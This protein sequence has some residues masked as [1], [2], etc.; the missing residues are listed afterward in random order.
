GGYRHPGLSRSWC[1]VAADG[2][3]DLPPRRRRGPSG[4]G[5]DRIRRA[6]RGP[7]RER[8]RHHADTRRI[9]GGARMGAPT[10]D[11]APTPPSERLRQLPHGGGR[12]PDS[13]GLRSEQVRPAESSQAEV[14]PGQ[15]LPPQPEHTPGLAGDTARTGMGLM[16]AA[17]VPDRDRW[18]REQAY[19]ATA[20]AATSAPP[21]A[22][23]EGGPPSGP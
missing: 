8:D 23:R 11:H 20:L 15:L 9:R 10:V 7:H 22:K 1:G 16:A 21:A 5:R 2:L 19:S 13:R 12:G 4:R 6:R 3:L 18:R 17:A 14:R